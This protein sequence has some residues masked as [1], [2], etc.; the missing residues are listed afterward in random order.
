[1]LDVSSFSPFQPLISFHKIVEMLE[2]RK[3]VLDGFQGKYVAELLQEI[4][5]YP[6]LIQGI[7]SMEEFQKYESVIKVLLADLF[8]MLLSNNEIKA[9]TIPYYFNILNLTQ[10]F[11]RILE[12]AGPDYQISLR[13]LSDQ[14][15]FIFNCC[16]II[17][18]YFQYDIEM[19]DTPMYM[20]IPDK[21]NITKHYRVLINADFMEIIPTDKAKILSEEE[22][23][24]LLNNYENLDLWLEKFPQNSWVLKG[25]S[26]M[27]L[28]DA[29]IENAVSQLKGNLLSDV[30]ENKFGELTEIFRSI[31]KIPELKIGITIFGNFLDRVNVKVIEQKFYSHLLNESTVEECESIFCDDM[32]R[33]MIMQ[34]NYWVVPD[35]ES[36]PPI[37]EKQTRLLEQLKTQNAR[38]IIFVPLYDKE[39]LLG[40]LELS[41]PKSRDFNSVN[42]RKMDYVLPFIQDKIST[43]L[44][45]LEN[46]IEAIIQK[47]YTSI[48]KSVQWRFKEEAYKYLESR[49]YATEYALKEI[50]FKDVYPMYGQIDVQG[51]SISRNEAIQKDLISQ[52]ESLIEVFELIY[53]SAKL[54]LFE[55][56]IFELKNHLEE[57][58]Q[59]VSTSTEQYIQNYFETEIHKV[60]LNFRKNSKLV[61][62]QEIIDSYFEKVGPLSGLF[63]KH[64]R[65]FDESISMINKKLAAVLDE[66]QVEAQSFFPHYYERFK[67]DGVEHNIFIG[68][69]IAPDREFNSYYL[70]NLRLWQ[71][72]VMCEMENHFRLLQPNLPQEL[73]VSSLILVFG[74]P[75][76]IRFRMDEKQFDIDGS[77]N[78]R[79]QIA[80]KRI[81]KAKIKNT[82]E[83]IT[84]KG[85]LTIVYQTPEEE[86]EYLGYIK[87]FQHKNM[88]DENVETF[89]VEDLQGII[90]LKGLRVGFLYHPNSEIYSDYQNILAA[91]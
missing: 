63:Y 15:W 84:Q 62:I 75:I 27:N 20:D 25:F 81:D 86:R 12:D 56:K 3:L 8:P 69:S 42:A 41:S 36:F 29:T 55:Q 49:K 22:I 53:I 10:R 54:P 24:E 23:M 82:D 87:L 57:L 32:V 11:K 6:E 76:S 14:N 79:Y 60:L 35:V 38:S 89:E 28:Y 30:D 17:R 71:M 1:M 58:N 47:E 7:E 50:V 43:V 39:K 33:K 34:K 73:Q 66:K 4:Q 37:D 85:K 72:Q 52:L 90:G 64:R 78:V 44:S 16:L 51:S 88:L 48:H 67:T 19:S 2:E 31:Y 13:G 59:V 5:K 70:Q 26:I 83:R 80:K 74:T 40:I 68:S 21:N 65:E 45:E 91:H 9:V 46:E 61:Q 77:Y 18:S